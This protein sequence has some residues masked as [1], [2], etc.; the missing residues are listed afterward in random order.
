[1]KKGFTLLEMLVVVIIIGVLAAIAMPYYQNAVQSARNTE[2]IIW[3]NKLK[4]MGTGK[5]MTAERAERYEKEIN[6]KG[7]LKYFT[8]K[9]VCRLKQDNE[10]CWEAE[11][12]LKNPDQ[13]IQYYIS[14]Q[15]NMLQLTCVPLNNAG[16]AFCST[17]AGQDEGPDTEIDGKPA[18]VIRF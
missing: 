16:D 6:E 1:M 13:N 10:I 7:L 3:W 12:H 15:K 2:A 4:R 18:Y 17:Q 11:L 8:A 5:N 9:M 14:T